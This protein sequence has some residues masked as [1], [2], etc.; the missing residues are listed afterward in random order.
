MLKR[1]FLIKSIPPRFWKNLRELLETRRLRC[2]RC[3]G[4]TIPRKKPLGKGKKS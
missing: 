3:N 4:V 1:I 2:A